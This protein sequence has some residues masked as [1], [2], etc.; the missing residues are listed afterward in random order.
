MKGKEKIKKISVITGASSGMGRDFVKMIDMIEECDE[1]WVIAR[2]REKLEELKSENGKVIR[3]IELDLSKNESIAE[4]GRMLENEKPQVT[5]LVNAAGFGKFGKFEDIPLEEQLNMIDLN[6][7]S[8]VAMTYITL[9]YIPEGGCI[10][11]LGSQSSFQPV[12][13]LTTYGATKAF[14]VS[15]TRAL[16]KELEKK[17]IRIMAVCP[18]WVKTEFFDRAVR[19]DTIT[20][21]S[22]FYESE[23]VVKKAFKDMKKGKDVSVCGGLINWQRFLAKILPHKM[24]MKIWCNQQKK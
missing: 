5:A 24:V 10:Y 15:F 2:R 13:Y 23:D 17:K 3:P 14:V 20:Y 22:K 11:Q 21:Y 1:I 7:K 18:G 9:P 19:D 16:N 12:P 8:L 6:S 4:Y